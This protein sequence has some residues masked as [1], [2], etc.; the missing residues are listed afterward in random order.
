MNL[1]NPNL[2]KACMFDMDGTIT[3]KGM[4]YPSQEMADALTNLAQK[5]PIAICTGRQLES[6]E[7][8]GL[9]Y[10]LKEIQPKKLERFLENLYLVAEN[11]SIG[12]NFNTD[13]DRFQEFYRGQWPEE[14]IERNNFMKQLDEEV[15]EFGEVVYEAHRVVV[16]VRTFHGEDNDIDKIY[17]RSA[18]IESIVKSFLSEHWSN[19]EEFFHIGNAG[20]GVV[21]CPADSDKDRGIKEFG[22]ILTKSRGY[23]FSK[24]Y[25]EI[26]V[27]GDN[28]QIRGND[29]YFLAGKYGIPFSVGDHVLNASPVKEKNGNRL[30]HSAGTLALIRE[31][32]Q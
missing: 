12:Y 8:H 22:D 7:S 1:E 20:I 15:S 14:I 25:R 11:G 27:I 16:V 23:E 21:V 6:F 13:L 19:F 18:E 17:N 26:L 9:N 4:H 32:L 3:D 28:P 24:N 30:L 29:H 2:I 5:M 31:I 10:L